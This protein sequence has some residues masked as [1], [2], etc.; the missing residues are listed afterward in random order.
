MKIKI[1]SYSINN[2]HD[3]KANKGDIINI[4]EK[5]IEKNLM[6]EL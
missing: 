4:L 5:P 6:V 1:K 3:F 2:S